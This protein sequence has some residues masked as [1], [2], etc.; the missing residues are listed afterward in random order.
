M[1]W[2]QRDETTK[3]EENWQRKVLSANMNYVLE[4]DLEGQDV[5]SSLEKNGWKEEVCRYIWL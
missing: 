1:F 5:N 3:T 4:H 2:A